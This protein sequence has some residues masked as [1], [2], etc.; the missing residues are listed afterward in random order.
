[1]ND[2]E[3][4]PVNL[5]GEG[6]A[7]ALNDASEKDDT[8]VEVKFDRENSSKD[9]APEDSSDEEKRPT[10]SIEEKTDKKS[11]NNPFDL[12]DGTEF[13]EKEEPE[14]QLSDLDRE[15]GR[16]EGIES[17]DI[18]KR[19][20]ENNRDDE[21][22]V[23]ESTDVTEE[24]DK[25]AIAP[26]DLSKDVEDEKNNPLVIA[27]RK[28]ENTKKETKGKTGIIAIVLSLLL[29]AALAAAA[30]FYMDSVNTST[31]LTS[32]ES[33]LES[34]N[35]K[36]ASLQAQQAKDQQALRKETTVATSEY[37]TIPEIGV[38]FKETEATKSLLFAYTVTSPDTAVDSIAFSTRA[39]ARVTEQNG[40][41]A[42][43]PC[44]FM[45]NI[46][47]I[48]RYATDMKIGISSASKLGKKIGDMYYVY[49]A[50]VGTCST[51]N[52]PEQA[53]RDIA[54]QAVY[55]GLE[56][57]PAT[58]TTKESATSTDSSS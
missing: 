55:N 18:G 42:T 43:Y 48:T 39:L 47:T 30:Y 31:R 25:K 19:N 26:V 17:A 11:D 38:R 9:D 33:E 51:K 21:M 28:Q 2:D 5:E 13:E 32:I 15:L 46:P 24:D 54:V 20:V 34:T 37:R 6:E 56:A 52:I 58:A 12:S 10:E 23:G 45:G 3:K 40:A 44:A 16:I 22:V 49:T 29:L 57:V 7:E 36:N 50:P 8:K 14:E 1:M 4:K 27:M 53:A 41:S 35:A